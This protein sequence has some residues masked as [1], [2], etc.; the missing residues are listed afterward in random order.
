VEAASALDP[1]QVQPA[2]EAGVLALV[3]LQGEHMQQA[4]DQAAGSHDLVSLLAVAMFRPV[5]VVLR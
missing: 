2:L 1:E 4:P 5:T 3:G